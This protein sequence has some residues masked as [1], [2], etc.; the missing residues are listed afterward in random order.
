MRR[1]G[2]LIVPLMVVLMGCNN[3]SPVVREGVI[4]ADELATQNE[5]IVEKLVLNRVAVTEDE[6]VKAIRTARL[7]KTLTSLVKEG[8]G[9]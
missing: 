5:V 8:V 3:L 2:W 1:L 9:Q 6:E 7:L 4:K